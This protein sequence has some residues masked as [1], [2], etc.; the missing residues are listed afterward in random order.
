MTQKT[1]TI[2]LHYVHPD[3]Q[4]YVGSDMVFRQNIEEAISLNQATL[5]P[6]TSWKSWSLNMWPIFN[7]ESQQWEFVVQPPRTPL[8]QREACFY[9][10]RDSTMCP[11]FI[12]FEHNTNNALNNI[13]HFAE[14]IY[15]KGDRTVKVNSLARLDLKERLYEIN[16]NVRLAW[17]QWQNCHKDL[18]N[19]S[20]TYKYHSR[21]DAILMQMRRVIDDIFVSYF[22]KKFKSETLDLGF[23]KVDSFQWLNDK[24]PFKN[25]PIQ[26]NCVFS[27]TRRDEMKRKRGL[28]KRL[29]SEENDNFLSIL[30]YA[31]NGAKH[32]YFNTTARAKIGNDFPTLLMNVNMKNGK[33]GLE[34]I[35]VHLSQIILG[36]TDL[37]SDV[38]TRA[39]Q[40]NNDDN[41]ADHTPSYCS[42]H[43]IEYYE[44]DLPKPV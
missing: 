13:E 23:Y 29:F 40:L 38:V 43:H 20:A 22:Y 39:E 1:N 12:N 41:I 9:S 37:L 27:D 11:T 31:S 30:T 44:L 15:P 26:K 7:L 2:L 25:W 28:I 34:E 36:F 8:V 42:R 4:S 24:K 6:L 5:T 14:L 18:T 3:D 10:G 16:E 33:H 19:G 21:I 35:N 17:E 32:S